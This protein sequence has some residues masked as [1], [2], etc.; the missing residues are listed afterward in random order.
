MSSS[1]WR[2][3]YGSVTLAANA[4][5]DAVLAAAADPSDSYNFVWN[6]ADP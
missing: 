4:D 5:Q 6:T 2:Y 3:K 1:V